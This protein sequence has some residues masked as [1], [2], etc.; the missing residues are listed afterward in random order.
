MVPGERSTADL[1]RDH[2]SGMGSWVADRVR[3]VETLAEAEPADV[4]I[5]G[6]PLTGTA[7]EARAVL[8][9]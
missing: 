2:V 9:G 5:V 8:D 3:V 7:E 4:V 1:L 6:E